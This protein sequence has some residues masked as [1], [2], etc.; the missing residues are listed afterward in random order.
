[1]NVD[2][3]HDRFFKETFS[4]LDILTDFLRVYLP[5]PILSGLDLNSLERETDSYTDD[6]LAEHFADLVFSAQFGEQPIRIALLLEHKS[7]TEEYPHFQLNRYLLNFWEQQLKQKQPLT[8]VLPIVVYHGKRRWKKRTLPD[9]FGTVPGPLLSFL[10]GFDYVLVDLSAISQR[11]PEFSTDYARV[12]GLLLQHSRQQR[13]FIS[14][15]DDLSD[16]FRRMATDAAGERFMET[17]FIYTYWTTDLTKVE[18]IAIFR[19]ISN[20]T[21]AIIMTTAERLINEGIEIGLEKG[22]EKGIE[23]GIRALLTLGMDVDSI[24]AA[25]TI[26]AAQVKAII[27]SSSQK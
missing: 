10:P 27:D 19:K 9:Y 4:R 12:T 14:L 5:E 24:A 18:L 25:L 17:A 15:F 2:N 3:P 1:M 22:L 20:Q 11:L 6:Q 13:K 16:I 8:P 26:P 21:E 23:K 7:Y